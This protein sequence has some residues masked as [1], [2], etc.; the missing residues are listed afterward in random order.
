MT[1]SE[2]RL[3]VLFKVWTQRLGLERWNIDV[4]LAPQHEVGQIANGGADAAADC[5]AHWEYERA[6]IRFTEPLPESDQQLES[7]VVHELMH[8]MLNE[9]RR[10]HKMENEERT[11]MMLTRAFLKVAA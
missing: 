11:A 6:T 9:I 10:Q 2:R 3:R 1:K 7:H 8:V 5:L 4:E